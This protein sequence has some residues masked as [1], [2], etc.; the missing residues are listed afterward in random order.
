MIHT[1]VRWLHIVAE[2]LAHLREIFFTTGAGEQSGGRAGSLGTALGWRPA[3]ASCASSAFTCSIRANIREK[4]S[5][6]LRG[7]L[8]PPPTSPTAA[9][10]TAAS[11]DAAMDD[12]LRSKPGLRRSSIASSRGQRRLA[13]CTTLYVPLS[14]HQAELSASEP[15]DRRG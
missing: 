7:G 4:L 2:R 6:L 9:A 5:R 11:A 3:S 8:C 12:G 10:G 13:G 1:G 15:G 14:Q